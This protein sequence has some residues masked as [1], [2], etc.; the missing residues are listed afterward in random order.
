MKTL[1]YIDHFKGINDSPE[2]ACAL[3][4]YLIGLTAKVNLIPYNGHPD[5]SFRSPDTG[6]IR[7]FLQALID[8]KVFVRLRA[9]KGARIQAACGQLGGIE[10]S[11]VSQDI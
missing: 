6:E 1:A 10:P 8:R 4:D 5:A 2:H 7:L 3:A 11:V 9:S